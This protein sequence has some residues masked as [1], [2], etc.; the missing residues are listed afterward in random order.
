[1]CLDYVN[2]SAYREYLG[3]NAPDGPTWPANTIR[4]ARKQESDRAS[5][6]EQAEKERMERVKDKL[7]QP[8]SHRPGLLKR[9]REDGDG[10]DGGSRDGAGLGADRSQ[11]ILIE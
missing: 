9:P 8:A 3:C 10:D 11:P 1:M 2:L 5:A 7:A 6:K 4:E